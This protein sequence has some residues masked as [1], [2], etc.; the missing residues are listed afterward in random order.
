MNESLK[1]AHSF[2][3]IFY[4]FLATGNKM[5][6]EVEEVKSS[7]FFLS[8][9]LLKLKKRPRGTFDVIIGFMGSGKLGIKI[10]MRGQPRGGVVKFEHSAAVA[11]GFTGSDPGR[12]HGTARQAM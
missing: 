4:K 3:E 12:G 11:Q 10:C 8:V 5:E 6:T 9:F 2:F 1:Q 7:L